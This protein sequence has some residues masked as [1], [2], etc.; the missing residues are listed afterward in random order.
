MTNSTSDNNNNSNSNLSPSALTYAVA[1]FMLGASAGM[2]LYTRRS[3]QML[4]RM[5]DYTANR[6]R[7]NPPHFGPPTKA[8]FEK[9]KNRW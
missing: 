8:E 5:E 6:L 7:R 9:M 2:T 1:F 3:G 4:S